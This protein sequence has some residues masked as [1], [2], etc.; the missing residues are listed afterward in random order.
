MIP[1]HFTP[2]DLPGLETEGQTANEYED[3]MM[4]DDPARLLKGIP[5]RTS[6]LMTI[7]GDAL[8]ATSHVLR[9]AGFDV[10][11]GTTG[12]QALEFAA[13]GTD[14]LL[15]DVNL[16]DIHGFDVCRRLRQD[17]CTTRLPVIHVSATFVKEINKAEG[18]DAGGD[19]YLTHPVEPPVLIATVNA[20]LR[21]RRAEDEMRASEAKFKAIF[22]NA[23]SG[24][25]LLDEHLTL[26]WRQPRSCARML[27]R[28]RESTVGQHR[29]PRFCHRELP[30][31]P[32]EIAHDA[33]K[34]EGSLARSIPT[35]QSR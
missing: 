9:A 24:I 17:P 21:A 30:P 12:Q 7:L 16:P 19:G 33:Q 35:A 18:L 23:P 4:L 25:L 3:Q 6:W 2:P 20:F 34:G 29:C 31:T 28:A 8:G 1:I 26:S 22:E 5:A 11:E 15:L 13:R 32:R 27:G 10:T 14:L